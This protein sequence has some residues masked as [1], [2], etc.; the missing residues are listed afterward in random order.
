MLFMFCFLFVIPTLLGLYIKSLTDSNC[1][2]YS[3][4]FFALGFIVM[5]GEFALICYP[6]I[7]KDIPFHTVCR[8]TVTVYITECL[9]ILLWLIKSR[10]FTL[11]A[12]FTKDKILSWVSSPFFWLMLIIC[13]FQIVRLIISEPFEMRDSKSYLALISDILQTDHLFRVNPDNGAPIASILEMPI[14]FSLSPWY[15]FIAMLAKTSRIHPLIISN[16]VLP[17]YLLFV[18]YIILF[19]LGSYLFEQRKETACSF[20]ALC[21]FIY[22]VSLYC[23]TPTMIRLVWPLWGKGTLSMTVVPAIL[24]LY[25]IMI[26]ERSRKKRICCMFVFLVITIAGC[27]MSTMAAL[28]LPLELC[29][30][31]IVW[32]IRKRS[33]PPVLYSIISCIPSALYVAIYYYLSSLR[34]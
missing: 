4:F 27:S 24:V 12:F 20:T 22:E 25:L 5:V 17:A 31:G 14:K 29:I 11:K 21:A 33:A 13:A 19:A 15:A 32:A 30:L 6:A 1:G 28:E 7:F 3:F 34:I 8:L 18:H 9:L 10:R 2:K 16:T 23:H 26:E